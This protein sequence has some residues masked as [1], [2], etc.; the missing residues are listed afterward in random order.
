MRA[1]L[2]DRASGTWRLFER[3]R[4]LVVARE[5]DDVL[6]ALRK[7]EAECG[8]GAHAAGFVAY[9]AAPAFD[10]ALRTKRDETFPLLWFGLYDAFHELPQETID[11]PGRGD[12]AGEVDEG[13]SG[14]WDASIDVERY[15][16]VFDRLQ[17]LIRAGETYQ[18]NF[19]YRLK[20]RM[21]V[22]PWALFQRLVSAQEP[23]FAAYLHAGEWIVCSASP[24]MFFEKSGRVVSSKPMKGT[25]A[26][27]LWYEDDLAQASRLKESAKERA[28]NV[29]IVDMV[30]NDLGRIARPGSV[31]VSKLFDVER[32]PTLW[33]MTSTVT[34]ETSATLA[35][36]MASLFPP[37]SIT[38]APRAST[39]AII[40]ELEC[41]PRR[42]YTGT[43]GFIDPIGRAQFNVAIRTALINRTTGEVEYGVGGGI[44]AD[45]N[46]EQEMAEAKLKSKVLSVNRQSF[47]LLETMLWK[48]GDGYLLLGHHLKRLMQS[49]EYFRFDVDLTTVRNR[50][51]G[52]AATL[53]H[54]SHRIRMLVS[55]AGAIELKASRLGSA[56]EKFADLALCAGPID[57]ADPFLYHKT[58]NRAVYDA[59]L[60]LRPE[61]A[62][63]LLFN[64]RNEITESTIANVV[65][66]C[67]GRFFTPPIEC[68]LLPG[69]ARAQLLQEGKIRERKIRLDELPAADAVYLVN[70]V[71]GLHRVALTDSFERVPKW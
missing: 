65:V 6:P 55:K 14:A 61:A 45:S 39:M 26:R 29:M 31:R 48:P 11:P 10:P 17:E 15:A 21:P 13:G 23:E 71:R 44:V 34:A 47:D 22:S 5:I 33:Q 35:E 30:R 38:G 32:Y 49:A 66:N 8:R 9:E 2:K 18:V 3:P 68:G 52:L 53:S 20:S 60:R 46:V 57:S 70:S 19:T 64:Q 40:A 27:G 36:V 54:D 28:E 51:A 69:T 62:D 16:R 12:Q 43:I 1:I 67:G 7:V 56:R 24:E 4:E 41:S 25:A 59:A 42:I 50:L 58:S 37:A 63:V